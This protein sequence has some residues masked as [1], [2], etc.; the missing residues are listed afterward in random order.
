MTSEPAREV[1]AVVGGIILIL[2]F[3]SKQ[4]AAEKLDE[5]LMVY[6]QATNSLRERIEDESGGREIATVVLLQPADPKA[7]ASK[8]PKFLKELEDFSQK[9]EEWCHDEGI[10]GWDFLH[11]NARVETAKTS[12]HDEKNKFGE[13]VGLDRVREVLEAVD[14]SAPSATD[15]GDPDLGTDGPDIFCS[16]KFKALDAELQQEMMGLKLSMMEGKDGVGKDEGEDMSSDQMQALMQ[17]VVA[18]RDTGVELPQAERQAFA[19]REVE[20]IIRELS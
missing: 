17:R 20:K 19:K 4:L 16:E 11:W 9:L 8:D 18:I 13:K 14:W 15:L 12:S 3:D 6:F 10:F 7:T 1:R 2:P 5:H